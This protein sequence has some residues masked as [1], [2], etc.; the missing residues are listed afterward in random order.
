MK[1]FGLLA[2]FLAVVLFGMS[3]CA[4]SEEASSDGTPAARTSVPGQDVSGEGGGVTPSANAGGAAAN[5][6]F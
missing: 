1:Y 4:S 3:G 5:V 6:R 2:A